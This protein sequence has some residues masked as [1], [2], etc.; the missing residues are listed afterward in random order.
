MQNLDFA[1]VESREQLWAK[2]AISLQNQDFA[3][4]AAL[5]E[6]MVPPW[7][8]M[9]EAKLGMKCA[10]TTLRQTLLQVALHSAHHRG[11]VSA[12]LRELGA[13]PPPTD[14]IAWL[15]LGKPQ[16]EWDAPAA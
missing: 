11:Q 4:L 10:P 5:T 15:W 8:P 6:S 2:A 14:F 13:E 7:G 1:V 12:R 9:V 3:L 16:P